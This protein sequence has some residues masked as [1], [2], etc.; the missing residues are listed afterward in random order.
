MR[1]FLADVTMREFL[2]NLPHVEN[3]LESYYKILTTRQDI[4]KWRLFTM[5]TADKKINLFLDSGAFSAWSKGVTIDIDEYIEFI[6]KNKKYLTVYSVL[7]DI[8]DP[9]ITLKNQKYM[10]SKGLKPLPCYHYGE[11]IK[12][13]KHYIDNYDYVAL[14]G[15]VPISTTNLMTWLDNLFKNYICD[16]KGMPRVK[17]HGFGLTAIPLLIRYP[18]FSVDSTSWVLTGRFGA[19]FVPVK[20]GGMYTYTEVPHKVIVSDQSPKKGDDGQH[21]SQFSQLERKQILEYIHAKGYTEKDIAENYQKRD[22]MN[23][24]YFQDL[25]KNL[26]TWPWPYQ[27][28]QAGKGLGLV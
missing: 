21:L 6:K 22:E 12:Y 7:D 19:I 16:A 23:I 24:I 11:D 4:T 5:A 15:M 25:E 9:E 2:K 10:E 13:L 17:I 27:P 18:W 28:K 1:I 26:P 3:N 8:G 14:G 20:K